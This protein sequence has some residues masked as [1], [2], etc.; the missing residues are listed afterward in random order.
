[1]KTLYSILA[2]ILLSVTAYA[3][4]DKKFDPNQFA[5]EQ[6]TYIIKEAR[7][8]AQ[9]AKAFFPIYREMQQKQ[10]TIFM[11][12]RN[13]SKSMPQSDKEAEELINKKNQLDIQ[14]KKIQCTYH[15][16]LCKS[17]PA[18]KV[19]MC[20]KADEHFKHFIMERI[21]HNRKDKFKK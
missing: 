7:L 3:Q 19:W 13:I 16:K 8:S 17:L 5:K 10:R 11:Q 14:F 18:R 12:M 21:S 6:E 1:M 20:I 4:Q 15:S 2:V 9:E